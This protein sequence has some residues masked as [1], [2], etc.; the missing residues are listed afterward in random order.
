MSP[1]TKQEVNKD[2]RYM[3]VYYFSFFAAG[4][5]NISFGSTKNHHSFISE[6]PLNS[7]P[8]GEF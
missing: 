4:G 6:D 1:L 7:I 5:N 3:I 2:V 8:G